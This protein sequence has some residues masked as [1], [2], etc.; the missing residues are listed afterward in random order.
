MSGKL[1]SEYEREIRDLLLNNDKIKAVELIYQWVKVG[2]LKQST[3]ISI[4]EDF[5]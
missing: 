1:Q 2:K 3:L 4:L 5:L